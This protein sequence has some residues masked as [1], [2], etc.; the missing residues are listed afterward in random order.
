MKYMIAYVDGSAKPNPGN[1]GFGIHIV[2]GEDG[3]NKKNIDSKWIVSDKGYVNK[4][5]KGKVPEINPL[6]VIDVYGKNVN[7]L[8]S[9]QA[10]L[11]AMIYVLKL[12]N[13][14]LNKDDKLIVH[15]DSEY[16]YYFV[17]SYINNRE[18]NYNKNTEYLETLK[19]M[20]DKVN[21]DFEVFK[22]T[23]HVGHLGN[24]EADILSNIGR[25]IRKPKDNVNIDNHLFIVNEHQMEFYEYWGYK[26]EMSVLL[27]KYK[28]LLITLK[29]DYILDNGNLHC[30]TN[31][32]K[33]DLEET[34][35]KMPEV[36]YTIIKTNNIPKEIQLVVDTINDGSDLLK[37]T[38]I[39]LQELFNKNI[40][41]RLNMYDINYIRKIRTIKDMV[42][43]NDNTMSILATEI[44]PESLSWYTVQ[45][46]KELYEIRDMIENDS[47]GI[48]TEDIKNVVYDNISNDIIKYKFKNG[49][50][51]KIRFKVDLPEQALF[52]KIKNNVTDVVV[53]YKEN[54][55]AMYD[56]GYYIK[57]DNGEWLITMGKYRGILYKR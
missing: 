52:K 36:N 49:V 45:Y 38:T 6:Y 31:Y 53:F 22:I 5:E 44:Y 34:G 26:P 43:T 11:D 13:E 30:I 35:K 42:V 17:N 18:N 3:K 16:V 29:N 12:A 8:T 55:N 28:Q 51:A 41:R 23:A 39:I 15:I 14:R 46:F 27:E 9:N 40:S 57:L 10:E 7:S 19:R 2:I 4:K 54:E 1:T 56:I 48:V 47:E 24:E 21:Y 20:L 25:L 32:K 50:K 37:P 33:S